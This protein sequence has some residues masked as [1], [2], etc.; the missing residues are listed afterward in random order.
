MLQ[1]QGTEDGGV[2]FVVADNGIGMDAEGIAKALTLFGQ[3]DSRLARKY[4][5][6]GLGLPLSQHLAES[7][8]GGLMVQSILGRGTTVTVTLPPACVIP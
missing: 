2:S 7:L 4:E 5:G 8:G 3:V 1:V 6:T